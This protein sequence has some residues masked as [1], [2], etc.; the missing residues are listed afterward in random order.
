MK[1][2][3]KAKPH[4]YAHCLQGLQEVAVLHGYNLLI[5][6]SMNRDMDLVAVPWVNEPKSHK[7]LLKSFCDYLG[8][9]YLTN[10]AGDPHHFSML[11]GGRYSYVVDLNRGGPRTHEDPQYYL[12]ISITPL[13][14][15]NEPAQQNFIEYKCKCG[16]RSI[17]RLDQPDPCERC[18]DCNTTLEADQSHCKE[19]IPHNFKTLY[20]TT[21]GKPYNQCF[22]CGHHEYITETSKTT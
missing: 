17:S 6:G 10:Q 16:A 2:P 19:P 9:P 21:D 15:Q 18:E 20:R 1:K 4:F 12:D 13:W 22:N 5:H 8:V 7:E 3:V 11:P 14:E